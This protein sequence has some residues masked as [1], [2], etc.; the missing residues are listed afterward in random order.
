MTNSKSSCCPQCSGFGE[1]KSGHLP[2]CSN[3]MDC[4][5]HSPFR[6]QKTLRSKC[7]ESTMS[8]S[9]ADDGTCCYIC[10][11]CKK[12]CDWTSDFDKF[13]AASQPA[14]SNYGKHDHGHC[15]EEKNPAC[16]QKIKH[17]ECCLCQEP[18]PEIQKAKTEG[19]KSAFED[20][21]VGD[22][23]W[24]KLKKKMA[25]QGRREEREELVAKLCQPEMRSDLTQSKTIEGYSLGFN[26]AVDL[27]IQYL[28]S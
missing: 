3:V 20:M 24:V 9:C 11:A 23:D 7:C 18:H 28:R 13:I 21:E 5:C 27:I 12:P 17:F 2:P 1:W 10:D 26:C 6:P 4:K 8:T 14:E 25:D 19:I 22:P 15:W 16:G